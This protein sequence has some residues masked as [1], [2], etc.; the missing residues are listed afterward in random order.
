MFPSL[1][2]IFCLYNDLRKV[3]AHRYSLAFTPFVCRALSATLMYFW[4][5]L[6]VS[7]HYF[8]FGS[9]FFACIHCIR[10]YARSIRTGGKNSHMSLRMTIGAQIRLPINRFKSAHL[11]LFM[12]V[13]PL[14]RLVK[15]AGTLFFGGNA[16]TFRQ[17]TDPFNRRFLSELPLKASS[18]FKGFIK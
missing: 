3:E 17:T 5:V 18:T 15:N 4:T 12:V 14:H 7:G 2:P 1:S 10:T 16:A 9:T 13:S 8:Q 11:L 6:T